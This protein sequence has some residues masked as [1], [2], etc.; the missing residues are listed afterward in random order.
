M[1][2]EKASDRIKVYPSTKKRLKIRCAKTNKTYAEL[3]DV[4]EKNMSHSDT[5]TK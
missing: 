5:F 4:M 1:K 2:K 3:I